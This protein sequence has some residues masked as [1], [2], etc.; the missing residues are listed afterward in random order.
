[1][2]KIEFNKAKIAKSFNRTNW[3]AILFFTIFTALLWLILQFTK[4]HNAEYKITI[5]FSE[6]PVKEVLSK[7]EIQL[8][9]TIQ[10]TG[11]SLFKKKFSENKISLPLST[12]QKSDSVYIFQSNLFITQISNKLKL[13]TEDF[14][15]QN[16]EI[17]IPYTTKSSKK[18]PLQTNVKVNYAKSY[19]S[20]GGI[21]ISKDS[22]KIAG[23]SDEIS[24]I[25][26]IETEELMLSDLKRDKSGELKLIKPFSD[27]VILEFYS[28]KYNIEVEK[29]TENSFILPIQLKNSPEDYKVELIPNQVTV[30]FQSSL[31]EMENIIEDDF[32]IECNFESALN[33][34]S[35][36][37]PKLVEKP[38]KAIRIQI[39]PN[40]IEY[41]LRK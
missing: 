33:E 12:L 17:K 18:I 9:T 1:M 7:K 20:Y 38:N 30:K 22:V 23:P 41:I 28:V 27:A 13:S 39:E 21:K 26:K 8:S 15:I 24:T 11:F 5:E 3:K 6:I 34:A 37:I 32:Q 14:N 31:N 35:I 19:A 2:S 40:Q 25:S 29:F 16:T 4:V 36:L 10:Q